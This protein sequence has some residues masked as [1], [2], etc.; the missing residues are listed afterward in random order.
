MGRFMTGF[1]VMRKQE[2][3]AGRAVLEAEPS[4]EGAELYSGLR[5]LAE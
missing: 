2:H 4:A 5:V 3:Q 1:E